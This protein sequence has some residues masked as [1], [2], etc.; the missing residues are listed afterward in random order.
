[1][2]D[3]FERQISFM[4]KIVLLLMLFSFLI[5]C[6][7]KEPNFSEEMIEVLSD[8]GEIKNDNRE[9]PPPPIFFS[10]FYLRTDS[11]VVVLLEER[12]LFF[13]YKKDY[14]KRFKS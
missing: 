2:L 14:S 10:D 5:S 13:F 9:L 11:G 1:M 4:K 8:R 6:E 12:E 3:L 7:R